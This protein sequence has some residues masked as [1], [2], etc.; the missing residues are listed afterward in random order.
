[1]TTNPGPKPQARLA[2]PADTLALVDLMREFYAESGYPLDEAGAAAA[3]NALLDDPSRG[4]VW[5]IEAGAEAVGHVV[6]SVRFAMEFAGLLA[7][8]DDLYVRPARRR[9]GAARAGLDALLAEC[10][11]R[12]CLAVEVEVSPDNAAAQALYR[13]C[14]LRPLGDRREHLR[15]LLSS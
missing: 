3:F 5:L 8:I 15:A 13:S 2:T 9:Q 6:L 1:V 14:G 4:N 12:G 11:R 7:Y 10:R